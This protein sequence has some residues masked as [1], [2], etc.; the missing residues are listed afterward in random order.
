MSVAV[1]IATLLDPS[2]KHLMAAD[3][4]MDDMKKLRIENTKLAV[5]KMETVRT[6]E[7][8]SSEVGPSPSRS[9]GPGGSRNSNLADSV[10]ARD[11]SSRLPCSEPY[12]SHQRR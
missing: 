3:L 9:S 8:I 6:L 10:A 12:V 5:E 4:T 2:T 7:S 11:S 1:Q